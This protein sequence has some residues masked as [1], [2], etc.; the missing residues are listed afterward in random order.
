[1]P[2]LKPVRTLILSPPRLAPDLCA[3]RLDV[4]D[5]LHLVDHLAECQQ[6]SVVVAPVDTRDE[7]VDAS[8]DVNG[9]VHHLPEIMTPDRRRSTRAAR[10]MGAERQEKADETTLACRVLRGHLRQTQRFA[11]LSVMARPGLEPGT[12]RFSVVRPNLSSWAEIP[13]KQ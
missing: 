4:I 8:P 13:G 6:L 3:P 1:M 5:V 9:I 10:E 2:S 11:G 12:P 7:A